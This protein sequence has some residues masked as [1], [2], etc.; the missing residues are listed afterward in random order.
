MEYNFS[1][2]DTVAT[3]EIRSYLDRKLAHVEKFI[4]RD[5][6]YKLDA[7]LRYRAGINEKDQKFNAAF[8]LAINGTTL[9]TEAQ[10]QSAYEAIDL[11]AAELTRVAAQH[12]SRNKSLVRRGAMRAK[13]FLQGIRGGLVR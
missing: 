9:H 11:A 3:P 12:K 13:E 1:C 10:G 6:A 2:I 5:A 7:D 8:T 4:H